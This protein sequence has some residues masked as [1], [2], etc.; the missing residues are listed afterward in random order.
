MIVVDTHTLIWF[1]QGDEKIGFEARARIDD[2][3]ST[4]EV[5]V[6][7]ICAWEVALVE[8]KGSVRFPGG[9]LA[10]MQRVFGVPTIRLAPLDIAIAIDSVAMAWQHKDPADRMIVATARHWR[11][12]LLTV[13]RQILD[14]AAAG[15]VQAIDARR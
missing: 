8:R 7:A 15:H 4:A 2:A 13:D 12:P 9:S 5:I 10:W 1:V 11:A 6:P 3:I 14:F